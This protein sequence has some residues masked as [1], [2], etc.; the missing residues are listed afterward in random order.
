MELGRTGLVQKRS[1]RIP[2][3]CNVSEQTEIS[4]SFQSSRVLRCSFVEL[5]QPTSVLNMG[6][7]VFEEQQDKHAEDIWH[8]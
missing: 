8:D 3:E 2:G 1:G 7:G 5:C 6:P 4:V